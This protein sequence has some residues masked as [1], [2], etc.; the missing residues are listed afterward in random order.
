MCAVGAT[1]AMIT[2]GHHTLD[3]L[4]SYDLYLVVYTFYQGAFLKLLCDDII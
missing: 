3:F 2:Y 1:T 4:S